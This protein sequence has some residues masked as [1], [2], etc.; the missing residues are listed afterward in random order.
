[1]DY[2]QATIH[3]Q[4]LHSLESLIFICF[5]KKHTNFQNVRFFMYFAAIRQ[6]IM[7]QFLPVSSIHFAMQRS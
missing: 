6:A 1:M 5:E 3:E 7:K 2:P 4:L